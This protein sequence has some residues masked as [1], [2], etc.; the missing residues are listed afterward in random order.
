MNSCLDLK[1][2]CPSL[3]STRVVLFTLLF[4]ALISFLPN[5]LLPHRCHT[6][7]SWCLPHHWQMSI[8]VVAPRATT[9]SCPFLLMEVSTWQP[10][11]KPVLPP[12]R[13]NQCKSHLKSSRGE[14]KQTTRLSMKEL[15]CDVLFSANVACVAITSSKAARWEAWGSDFCSCCSKIHRSSSL[16]RE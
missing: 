7:A 5:L 1:A 4:K 12:P 9:L 10:S 11:R 6:W 15:R 8:A 14:C 13:G 3:I 2:F 16:N